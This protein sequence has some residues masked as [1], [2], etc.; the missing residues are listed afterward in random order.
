MYVVFTLASLALLLA[1]MVLILPA[2]TLL[3]FFGAYLM[4]RF[5][6]SRK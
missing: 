6:E 1:G 4:I 2:L 5:D 3:C